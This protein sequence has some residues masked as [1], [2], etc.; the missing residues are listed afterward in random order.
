V[1]EREV[2]LQP[3]D[4]AA[5]GCTLAFA[6]TGRMYQPMSALAVLAG[7]NG[8]GFTGVCECYLRP[9]VRDGEY[10]MG[11]GLAFAGEPP[12]HEGWGEFVGNVGHACADDEDVRLDRGGCEFATVGEL[13][14]ALLHAGT[15]GFEDG[16][17]VWV[18]DPAGP[19]PDS[20]FTALCRS[21]R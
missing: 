14:A 4:D 8:K 20:P 7:L 13:R 6:A 3:L 5:T 16:L 21:A 19:D 10:L 12:P 11:V 17:A 18:S 15:A 9:D 2:G 1:D